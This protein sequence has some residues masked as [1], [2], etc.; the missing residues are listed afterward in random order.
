[1]PGS[2]V[3]REDLPQAAAA[4]LQ[5]YTPLGYLIMR[6]SMVLRAH[7]ADFVDLKLANGLLEQVHLAAPVPVAALRECTPPG[8]FTR[9]LRALA[10]EGVSIRDARP[11]VEAVLNAD[12]VVVG[13][14]QIAVDERVQLSAPPPTP[15]DPALLLAYVR[16]ALQRMMT[17]R[18]TAG[19]MALSAFVVT[20]EIETRAAAGLLTEEERRA[21]LDR[22]RRELAA[23][24]PVRPVLLTTLEA[25]PALREAIHPERADVPV[26]AYQELSPATSITTLAR[27]GV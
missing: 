1:L 3:A 25:R 27:L 21:L 15:R 26:V 19:Q 6:L 14:G 17:Y 12:Y 23:A 18:L 13:S 10:A 5:V 7:A 2:L 22:L 11:I 16:R 8:D 9:V 20:P 24:G 4:P